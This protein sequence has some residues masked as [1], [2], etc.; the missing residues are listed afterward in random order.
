[1]NVVLCVVCL[2][3]AILYTAKIAMQF[4]AFAVYAKNGNF[5]FGW[6]ISFREQTRWYYSE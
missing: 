4:G 2:L 3:R 5:L 6:T 1:M